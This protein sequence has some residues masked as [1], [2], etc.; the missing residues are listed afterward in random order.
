MLLYKSRFGFGSVA[1]STTLDGP[2]LFAACRYFELWQA[3]CV[4]LEL[5]AV[6]NIQ[7]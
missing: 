1:S 7:Q 2:L 3:V 5:D 6:S 4:L